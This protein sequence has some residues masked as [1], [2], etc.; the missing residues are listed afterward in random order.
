M[1]RNA[2]QDVRFFGVVD[3]NMP[4]STITYECLFESHSADSVDAMK[5]RF[6]LIDAG[7]VLLPN[8]LRKTLGSGSFG[9][10]VECKRPYQGLA[11]KLA[12]PGSADNSDRLANEI[13]T[14]ISL[15]VAAGSTSVPIPT[16]HG[17]VESPL[18]M[19]MPRYLAD[20]SSLKGVT[21]DALPVILGDVA[22]ALEFMHCKGYIHGDVKPAN[23]LIF[24]ASS[25]RR[26][27]LADFNQTQLTSASPKEKVGTALYRDKRV[28][29]GTYGTEVDIY[30]TGKMLRT[31]RTSKSN[32]DQA[33][34]E[35]FEALEAKCCMTP[36]ECRPSAAEL[37]A[38]FRRWHDAVLKDRVEHGSNQVLQDKSP[39]EMH[40]EARDALGD[41]VRANAVSPTEA[42]HVI[43]QLSNW[44][45]ADRNV[46]PLQ[47]M[48]SLPAHLLQ[49]DRCELV[50]VSTKTFH[51]RDCSYSVNWH[52]RSHSD[53]TRKPFK[54][55]PYTDIERRARVKPCNRCR[56]KFPYH[57]EL[58]FQSDGARLAAPQLT[59]PAPYPVTSDNPNNPPGPAPQSRKRRRISAQSDAGF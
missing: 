37:V 43:W 8:G 48:T 17:I 2:L 21:K 24:Q 25:Q 6:P 54:I 39:A 42:D 57:F 5:E 4:P 50:Y 10:V 51:H 59:R 40:A 7:T 27:I 31:I 45:T 1:A 22:R 56:G 29:S 3:V 35:V 38:E 32:F 46:D 33:T 14:L 15:N 34:A 20:L 53:P 55:L 41:Q 11:A 52:R 18:A 28:R 13:R 58:H 44:A 36:H 47:T 49:V 30:A 9:T 16:I 12:S 19:V 23:V 26:G